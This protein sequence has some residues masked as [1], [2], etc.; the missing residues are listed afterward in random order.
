MLSRTSSPPASRHVRTAPTSDAAPLGPAVRRQL[1]RADGCI[2][3]RVR[4]DGAPQLL[5]LH[6]PAGFLEVVGP[7]LLRLA[8]ATDLAGVGPLG[9]R[10]QDERLAMVVLDHA[11]GRRLELAGRIVSSGGGLAGGP[12]VVEIDSHEWVC[13]ADS[14][15]RFSAEE[16]DELDELLPG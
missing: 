3:A 9:P 6:G 16:L 11:Q 7:R 2:L 12:L 4:A 15:R 8:P 1:R 14:T 10:G 5:T 13:M